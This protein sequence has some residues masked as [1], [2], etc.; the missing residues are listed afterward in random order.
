MPESSSNQDSKHRV[1]DVFVGSVALVAVALTVLVYLNGDDSI[2]PPS[3]GV[4]VAIFCGLLFIG[5][6]R[7]KWFRFGDG[8]QV[9]PGWAF[10]FSI[11]LLG[12]PVVAIAAMAACTLFVDVRDHK[13]IDED[14]LQRCTDHRIARCRSVGSRSSRSRHADHRCRQAV[15]C[16]GGSGSS[17]P[18]RSCSRPMAC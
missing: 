15:V 1:V 12:A 3:K 9:T 6:T 2:V 8:G 17:W 4:Y 16:D 18:E 7:T 5:E 11:V 10:A 14:R 13:I